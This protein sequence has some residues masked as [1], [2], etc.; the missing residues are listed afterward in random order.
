MWL[1]KCKE[2]PEKTGQLTQK[3]CTII[4][5]WKY[6]IWFNDYVEDIKAPWSVN[7]NHGADYEVCK[8]A[9]VK[10]EV[11]REFHNQSKFSKFL[12]WW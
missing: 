5:T 3:Q 10:G 2:S 11:L 12:N 1:R 4:K 7:N 8:S 9:C 6:G